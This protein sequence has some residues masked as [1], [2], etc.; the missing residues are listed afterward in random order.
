[1]L[2]HLVGHHCDVID[3]FLG[4][5]I[6]FRLYVFLGHG[7]F[8]NNGSFVFVRLFVNDNGLFVNHSSFVKNGSFFMSGCLSTTMGCVVFVG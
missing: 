8:V 7:L 1:M 5:V 2:C 3:C 6:F 4:R